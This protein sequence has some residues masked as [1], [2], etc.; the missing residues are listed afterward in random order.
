VE[1]VV[2]RMMVRRM[3]DPRAARRL[4]LVLGLM[5]LAA[6]AAAC[7]G[8]PAGEGSGSGWIELDDDISLDGIV[9]SGGADEPVA[10]SQMSLSEAE[11]ALPFAVGLPAWVPPGFALRD[12]VEV[13]APETAAAGDYAS[14]ILTWE[15]PDGAEVQLQVS[16]LAADQP[17]VGA[18]GLGQ[19][20]TVNG[21]PG[22]LLETQG[23]GPDRL[24]LSW[25]R[26]GLS[27]RLSATGGSLAAEQLLQMAESIA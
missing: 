7:G 12:R 10:P 5:V 27:Y 3:A 8:Q 4:A 6:L 26:A 25:S 22:T 14:L 16:T 17:A 15:D 11:A 18:A 21:L 23:L 9:I 2:K 19:P 20:V 24:S 13:I 1:V